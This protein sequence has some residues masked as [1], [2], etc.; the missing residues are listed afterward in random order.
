MGREWGMRDVV[1]SL[2]V[3]TS[4]FL[5]SKSDLK[6]WERADLQ[7]VTSSVVLGRGAI[8]KPPSRTEVND[9]TAV[10]EGGDTF[11]EVRSSAD[12]VT[13]KK[14]RYEVF[15]IVGPPGSGKGLLS[16]ALCQVR[17]DFHAS[18]GE[19]LRSL[20]HDSPL[21]KE[22]G[23]VIETGGLIPDKVMFRVLENRISE[24]EEEGVLSPRKQAI[25]LDGIPRTLEQARQIQEDFDVKSVI[26]LEVD[27][28]G[29]LLE[30]LTSRGGISGRIDDQDRAVLAKR[31]E[32][33][34]SSVQGILGE[35]K[36]PI[37]RVNADQDPILVLKEIL[38]KASDQL[39][40]RD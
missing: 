2:L 25:W 23:R 11:A 22:H 31:I 30:R 40:K 27:N 39:V 29:V 37:I 21:Y 8:P 20:E 24:K 1:R 3:V 38:D 35:F 17:R 19:I 4:V 12:S 9:P 6:S 33:Y 5:F 15:V 32:I 26:L 28:D 14:P 34:R 10:R 7:Q 16:S 13:Q 18:V 36:K